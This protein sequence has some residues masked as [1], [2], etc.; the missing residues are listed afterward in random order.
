MASPVVA[1]STSGTAASSATLTATL[2]L[3]GS[4]GA[5]DVLI[6]IVHI[7]GTQT[8]TTWPSGWVKLVENFSSA[9]CLTIAYKFADGT[10]SGASVNV[11]HDAAG[12]AEYQAYRLTG[13]HHSSSP[14]GVITNASINPAS[15]SWTW[16][17][18]DNLA[19]AVAI[20][21]DFATT[22]TAN[23]TNYINRLQST[24]SGDATQRIVSAYRQ[25]TGAG[26]EDPGAWSITGS[27]S[28]VNKAATLVIKPTQD[29]TMGPAAM[30][31]VGGSIVAANGEYVALSGAMGSIS[32]SAAIAIAPVATLSGA[33]GHVSGS[34]ALTNGEYVAASGALGRVAGSAAIAM[35]D[36]LT[37]AGALRGLSGSIVAALGDELAAAGAMGAISGSAAIVLGDELSAAGALGAI[38]GEIVGSITLG[39]LTATLVGALGNVSGA[40]IVSIAD[41]I[42]LS[43]AL[44]SVSGEAAVVIGPA[45]AAEGALGRVSGALTIAQGSGAILSGALAGVGSTIAIE[46]TTEAVFAGA[47]GS[48]GAHM[49]VKDMVI[50]FPTD[51][52]VIYTV[53][54][55][56][57]VIVMAGIDRVTNTKGSDPVAVMP[58]VDRTIN[59][60]E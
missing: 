7:K 26:P 18:A 25:F 19:I 55:H 36:V 54:G 52:L 6:G 31:N 42:T 57:R 33:L 58:A 38:G 22:V 43:G 17:T 14:T 5:A 24:N 39:A 49:H 30:G 32:G 16:G 56:D 34:A 9:H 51:P 12:I 10:E 15:R 13:A 37:A 35:T 29:I 50:P 1:G 40:A 28:S 60:G 27:G 45:L 53:P 23:P 20:C 44:G 48:I 59:A 11:T 21:D 47:M 8:T 41:A 4:I 3:P 46:I 2:V